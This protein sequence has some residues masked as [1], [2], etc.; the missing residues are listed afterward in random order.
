MCLP[1]PGRR[2]RW[3]SSGVRLSR[4][5]LATLWSC[6]DSPESTREGDISS[7]LGVRDP[8]DIRPHRGAPKPHPRSPAEVGDCSP[9][10]TVTRPTTG[11][12]VP[13]S[14]PR[15]V[16]VLI[17]KSRRG[18]GRQKTRSDDSTGCGRIGDSERRAM[19]GPL[20]PDLRYATVG[21]KQPTG[22]AV[23]SSRQ[24]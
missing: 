5:S 11:L 23:P 22:R 24:G 14:R 17:A 7:C 12:R 21:S 2:R 3:T 16:S 6:F 10:C 8:S 13:R 4:T 15:T 19:R 9:R 18:N 20:P 1:A